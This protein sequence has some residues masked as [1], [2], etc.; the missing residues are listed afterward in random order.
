ME[1]E[2]DRE[3]ESM[4]EAKGVPERAKQAEATPTEWVLGRSHD[5]DG[6]HVGGTG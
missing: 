4:N 5:L 6:T 3:S 2:K 1:A